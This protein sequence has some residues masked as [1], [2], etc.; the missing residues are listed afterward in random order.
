MFR[1][2]QRWILRRQHVPSFLTVGP[3]RQWLSLRAGWASSFSGHRQMMIATCGQMELP[4]CTGYGKF[5]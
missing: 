5:D 2:V 4:R 1:F 3:N